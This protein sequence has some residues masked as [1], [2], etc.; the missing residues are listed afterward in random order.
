MS[1][2]GN[3]QTGT[4]FRDKSDASADGNLLHMFRYVMAFLQRNLKSVQKGEEFNSLDSQV[5]CEEG[6][7][8]GVCV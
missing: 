6:S 3:S 4:Q 1:F 5:V 8:E 2:V 7:C